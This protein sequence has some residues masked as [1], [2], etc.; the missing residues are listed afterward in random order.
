VVEGAVHQVPVA[1]GDR[2][3]DPADAQLGVLGDVT[4]NLIRKE[5]NVFQRRRLAGW[6]DYRK[7][8][9]APP[10]PRE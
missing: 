4:L 5:R 3:G 6:G 8:W 7:A 9:I 1:M 2:A 10:A